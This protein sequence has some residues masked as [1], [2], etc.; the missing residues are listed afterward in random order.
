MHLISVNIGQERSIQNAKASGKTGIYK[1]PTN[2]PVQITADGLAGDVICDVENHGGVDQ[3]VYLFGTADYAWWSAT[4][5][6]ELAPGTFGENLTISDLTSA[7]FS[8]GDCLHVGSVIL[9]VT[10]PR[11]PCVTLAARMGDPTFVKRFRYAERPGLYCRVLQPGFVQ[12]GDSVTWARYT[13][14]TITAIE[15][16]RDFYEPDLSEANLRR[17]LAAPIA[18]RDRVD[19]EARLQAISK[20]R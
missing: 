5:G 2:D 4:L 14:A 1:L 12:V 11:I 16:F 18:I 20:T 13:G 7:D 6:R 10:A 15:M 3:A 17:Y 9:Q 19:K 8:I